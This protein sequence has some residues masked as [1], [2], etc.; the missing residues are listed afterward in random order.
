MPWG[1]RGFGRRRRIISFLQPCLLVLLRRD[2]A[3][4]YSLLNDLAE[5]GFDPEFLDPS[6]V[7]RALREMEM[8]GLVISEW[9]DESLGPQR[10][11]YRVTPAGEEYLAQWIADLRQTRREIDALLTAYDAT[12]RPRSSQEESR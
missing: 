4:G 5:F 1:G 8:M 2:Q 10:R 3:H 6:L 11:I 9:S 12:P 7:Y